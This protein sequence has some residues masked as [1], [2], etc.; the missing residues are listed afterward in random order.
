MGETT[1]LSEFPALDATAQA[2]LVRRGEVA[3]IELVE[4]AIARIEQLNPQLNAVI[5][6]LFN[7]ARTQATDSRLPDGPFRGVPLLVKDYYCEIAGT[8][9]YEGLR[10]LRDLA[11]QSA[12][13]TNLGAKFRAA[14]FVFLGKTNLP[15]LALGAVTDSQAFGASRNPFD[16]ARTTGGSSG[17]SAAAVASGMVAVAHGND[18]TGSIRVPA[19]CCGLVGLK[20]SRGRISPGPAR[21]GGLFGSIS[22]FVLTRSVR[23]AAAI[24]DAV[25]GAMPGDLFVAPPPQRPYRQEV[26]RD[27]GR[28][29]VGLMLH[30]AALAQLKTIEPDI[31]DVHPE[32]VAAVQETGTLLESLGH[33]VEEAYPPQLE[34]PTGLGPALGIISASALAAHLDAWSTRTG[35]TIGRDDVEPTTWARAEEGRRY[36][37]VEIHAAYQRLVAGVCRVPEWWAQGFDLL[38]TPTIAQPPPEL[39]KVETASR[40]ELTGMFGLLTMPYNFTGQPAISLPLHWSDGGLPIGVQLVADYGREDLLIRVASQLEAVRPWIDHYPHGNA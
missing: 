34:G 21:S 17:G 11:W 2:E 10:F 6:P 27:P 16:L 15:E 5:T 8:P 3:P 25:A 40:M 30:D 29:R 1:A 22:E 24:L 9:Y 26:G 28:L 31:P 4:A 33:D 18:G 14:G 39:E 36:T 13:D 23:D 35:R 20:P 37:A 38:V 19:S 7:Q 12:H 32:C